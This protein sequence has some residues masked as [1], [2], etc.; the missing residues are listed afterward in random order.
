MKMFEIKQKNIVQQMRWIPD[1]PMESMNTKSMGRHFDA[2][3]I[4]GLR[5][6]FYCQQN[7]LSRVMVFGRRRL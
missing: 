3:L 4:I 6:G 5:Y 7:L 2:E 1:P